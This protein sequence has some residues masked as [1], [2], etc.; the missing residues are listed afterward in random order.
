MTS[1]ADHTAGNWMVFYSNGAGAVTQLDSDSLHSPTRHTSSSAEQ[2]RAVPA[3]TP[4]A[5]TSFSVQ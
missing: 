1:A 4:A 2:S 3:H 5:H